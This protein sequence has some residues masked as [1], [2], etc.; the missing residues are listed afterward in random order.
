MNEEYNSEN[1]Y[2]NTDNTDGTDTR[3]TTTTADVNTTEAEVKDANTV[4]ALK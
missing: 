2:N 3:E 4:N 1:T